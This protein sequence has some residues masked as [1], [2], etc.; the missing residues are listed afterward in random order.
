MRE[1]TMGLEIVSLRVSLSWHALL[2]GACVVLD[3][4]A[5]L[6]RASIG[7]EILVRARQGRSRS[8]P[9]RTAIIHATL[10][11]QLELV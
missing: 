8:R 3:S 10:T 6:Q 7:P 9:V 2:E 4:P 5:W 11:V 1:L